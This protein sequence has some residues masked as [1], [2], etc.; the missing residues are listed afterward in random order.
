[1]N[2]PVQHRFENSAGDACIE[3]YW[4]AF[5]CDKE[6][7]LLATREVSLRILAAAARRHDAFNR[8]TEAW[9]ECP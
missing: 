6:A 1:M 4:G 5:F 8:L 2:T 9:V 7:P 3:R